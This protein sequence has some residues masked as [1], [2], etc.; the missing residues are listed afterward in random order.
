M[1]SSHLKLLLLLILSSRVRLGATISLNI[2]VNRYFQIRSH[3][4]MWVMTSTYIMGVTG[5][6][7]AVC[8]GRVRFEILF[9]VFGVQ[10]HL[11]VLHQLSN[12]ASTTILGTRRCSQKM[13]DIQSLPLRCLH[14]S[15]TW[16]FFN[17]KKEKKLTLSFHYNYREKIHF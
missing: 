11:I 10:I 8:S 13:T 14:T 7:T 3:N 15:E 4:E 17:F 2:S 16:L 6:H 1:I 12:C 9:C 5:Q